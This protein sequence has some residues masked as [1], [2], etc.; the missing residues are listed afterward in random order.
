MSQ[1]LKDPNHGI[2][3]L[4][5]D[6]RDA[7]LAK[8]FALKPNSETLGGAQIPNVTG[9]LETGKEIKAVYL[10]LETGFGIFSEDVSMLSSVMAKLETSLPD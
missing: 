10:R 9:K 1:T 4:Y 7:R 6:K 5:E 8:C 2:E 3:H